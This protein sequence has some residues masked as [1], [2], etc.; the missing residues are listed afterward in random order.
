M[1]RTEELTCSYSGA[2]A[3][4][5]VSLHVRAGELV[6]LVGPSGAGKSTLLR[7]FNGFVRPASGQVVVAGRDVGSLRGAALQ[8]HR[9]A[10]GMV[11]Q[12]FHLVGR[13][14]ALANALSGAASRIGSVRTWLGAAPR[15]ELVRALDALTRVG[16]ADRWA[17]RA[18][19][20]SGGQQ[21]RVAIA[22]TLVQDPDI[23]LADEP[24]ASLDPGSGERVLALLASLAHDDG[25]T[26]VVSLHQI[27]FARRWC[28]RI[29]AIDH[30]NIV[31]DAPA[32]TVTEQQWERLYRA[33]QRADTDADDM[34]SVAVP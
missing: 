16:L 17:Q 10:V 29:I 15:A 24:V 19:T 3:L 27:G 6:G 25:R 12:R 28:D 31:I 34:A 4:K 13:A 9:A 7:T 32:P 5:G 20:L 1:I 14:T 8:R 11:Y 22:R 21:Q 26:V 33:E 18:D 23:V 30:G 2:R